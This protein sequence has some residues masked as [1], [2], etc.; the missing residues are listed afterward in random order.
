MGHDTFILLSNNAIVDCNIDI[1]YHARTS[2]EMRT[3]PLKRLMR[4]PYH[5][6]DAN[7][8]TQSA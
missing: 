1:N 5:H 2:K 6:T 8:P 4:A 3:V 7:A